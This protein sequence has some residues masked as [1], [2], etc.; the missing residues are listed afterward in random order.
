[1]TDLNGHHADDKPAHDRRVAPKGLI[2]LEQSDHELV[3]QA[4]RPQLARWCQNVIDGVDKNERNAMNLF[5]KAM[6]IAGAEYEININVLAAKELG[7]P[8]AMAK[9]RL[10]M[11]TMVEGI[12]EDGAVSI[13]EQHV[14]AWYAQR[15]KRV[16]IVD[17]A[18]EVNGG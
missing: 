8:L 13:M 6:R 11:V 17:D 7:M 10:G 9:R 4:L 16:V 3:Q 12:D 5:A 15:G 18:A 2:E 1:M 14:R